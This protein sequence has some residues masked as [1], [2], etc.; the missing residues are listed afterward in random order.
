M[1]AAKE[2][3]FRV[4]FFFDQKRLI[5]SE[6]CVVGIFASIVALL[7][8]SGCAG[9]LV[10]YESK[11]VFDPQPKYYS[12]LV[13][14]DRDLR[15]EAFTQEV[16]ALSPD[17]SD[18]LAVGKK[19]IIYPP[20]FC[21]T[22][23]AA[24]EGSQQAQYIEMQCGVLISNLERQLGLS[25]Y[26]VI[27][28][29]ILR[30][31]SKANFIE[32]AANLNIDVVFEV[33]QLSRNGRV[34]GLLKNKRMEIFEY[35]GNGQ[36]KPLSVDRHVGQRCLEQTE[37]LFEELD[38]SELSAT[39]A[40]KAV[41]VAT[42]RAVWYYNKTM[43]EEK[44]K[45]SSLEEEL[46][47]VAEPHYTPPT[48]MPKFD[49][50]QLASRHGGK[51]F[52][53]M[54]FGVPMATVGAILLATGGAEPEE[55]DPYSYY[56]YDEEESSSMTGAQT[57]GTILLSLGSVFTIVGFIGGLATIPNMEEVNKDA[58]AW[59]AKEFPPPRYAA[60]KDVVCNSPVVSSPWEQ[61]RESTSGSGKASVFV[62]G[63]VE[64]GTDDVAERKGNKL[65][66]RIAED[67][68]QELLILASK[69]NKK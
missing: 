50:K 8:S 67:F 6:R 60:P 24:P 41:D 23:T 39:L 2:H 21:R 49:K 27:S 43:L 36:R 13:L 53:I 52:I 31:A 30:S 29:Q 47:F 12:V 37:P 62:V 61:T 55:E 65:F 64:S 3:S 17:A 28:W 44:V 54:G 14:A 33:D 51:P 16:N 48:Q 1:T 42:G 46:F 11:P 45:S 19:V 66:R 7:L 4:L 40:V 63:T 68:S 9:S 57:V 15:P 20:D 69:V 18:V 34:S 32:S 58:V 25:G 26:Q 35:Q 22:T 5:M 56:P 38:R 10:P 59:N